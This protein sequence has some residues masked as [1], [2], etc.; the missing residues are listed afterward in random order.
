MSIRVLLADDH[1]I[2]R[3]GVRL[4][5]EQEGGM[6][7]VAEAENGLL[8]VQATLE[9]APDVVVMDLTM[10]QMNGIDATRLI[11][12]Q[13]SGAA[14]LILS[15]HMDK[16]YI[17]EA[18]KAG[19]DG[20]L[21]KECTSEELIFAIRTVAAGETFLS[22]KVAGILVESFVRSSSPPQGGA[23]SSSQ[24]SPREREVLQLIAEGKS[25]KDIAFLF[26]LSG[27]TVDTYRLQIMRKLDLHSIADLTRFAIRE[28]IT[29]P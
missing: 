18:L 21:P 17:T 7:I 9:T 14:V 1:K 23:P 12:A 25:T 22:P 19:A 20:F 28:G 16:R 6:E 26:K 27:K 8:A 15:V 5:L 3:A 2:L 29:P 24:L 11:K 10:P 13:A 4:I